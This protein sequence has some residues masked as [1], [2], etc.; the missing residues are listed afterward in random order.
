MDLVVIP[1]VRALPS[2][3]DR[4][5]FLTRVRALG[6]NTE[7]HIPTALRERHAVILASILS[8]IADGREDACFLEEIR[9]KLLLSS[10]PRKRN[11]K[12]ESS[13]RLNLW[14]QQDLEQLLVRVEEQARGKVIGKRVQTSAISRGRRAKHLVFEGAR[15][16]VRKNISLNYFYR[17]NIY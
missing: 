17:F 10:I 9:S 1:N 7:V 16:R 3:A 4:E 2:G 6:S 5:A 13:A 12:V 14:V 8:D 11:C 15:S